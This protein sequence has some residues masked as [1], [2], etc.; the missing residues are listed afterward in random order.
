MIDRREY[1]RNE[2]A[3]E[4][5]AGERKAIGLRH[6]A[7]PWQVEN[8]PYFSTENLWTVVERNVWPGLRV[9]VGNAGWLGESG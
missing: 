8:L 4:E 9:V 6:G 5:Q 3:D 2:H 1:G 7:S